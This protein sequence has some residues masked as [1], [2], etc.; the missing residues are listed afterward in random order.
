M[1]LCAAAVFSLAVTQP[2]SD[3]QPAAP[4][5]EALH[6][7]LNEAAPT[8]VK[9]NARALRPALKAGPAVVVLE[10][11]VSADGAVPAERLVLPSGNKTL[12][13]AA[14]TFV[15]ATEPLPPPDAA[16]LG[17]APK[18]ECIIRLRFE[19]ARRKPALANAVA[20]LQPGQTIGLVAGLLPSMATAPEASA[21]LFT[22]WSSDGGGDDAVAVDHYR[23][24]VTAAPAWDL[25]TRA[26]G[27]S[28]VKAKKV[29]QAIPYLKTYVEARSGA[30][31]ALQ[32]AREIARYEKVMAARIAEENRVRDRLSKKDI[33]WGIKKGYPLLEPCLRRA[34]EARALAVG[35]DTIVLTWKVRKDGTAHSGRLEA[36]ASMMMSEHADCIA[37]AV[38]AWRF[39]KY[40]QGS[41]ITVA[42][43]PIK[44]RGSPAPRPTA[45][46]T[47]TA[48]PVGQPI[49]EPM[50]AQCE[51]S[52]D[53]IS[54]HIRARQAR[55]RACILAERRRNP[56]VPMPDELPISFVLDSAGPVRNITVNHRAYRTGPLASCVATALS[57]RLSPTKGA[58]CPAEFGV[59]LR[60][61]LPKRRY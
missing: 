51:R 52:P 23:A 16:W 57:G 39:P 45:A 43:V 29:S 44:V 12:D 36:P 33:A 60:G 5:P 30:E 8:W 9:S 21:R 40:S 2:A 26:L 22:G 15:I 59:D 41:E 31:D 27:L 4:Y 54:G 38:G 18:T 11:E 25:A 61:F 49:D 1:V 24:A 32:Y 46:A 50:F 48:A 34:R 7:A 37:Q 14:R 20:C 35:A 47:A 10:A 42:K 17:E 56:R 28:L 53:E 58:D 19:L 3:T 55:L 13:D 6:A